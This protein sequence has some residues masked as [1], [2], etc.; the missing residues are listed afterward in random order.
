MIL[1]LDSIDLVQQYGMPGWVEIHEA[2]ASE[3][4][5]STVITLPGGHLVYQNNP[6]QVVTQIDQFLTAMA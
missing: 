3:N 5:L 1:A 6:D 4:P 2:V